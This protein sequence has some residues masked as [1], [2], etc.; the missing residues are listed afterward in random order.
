MP[1]GLRGWIRVLKLFLQTGIRFAGLSAGDHSN[2]IARKIM[3][4]LSRASSS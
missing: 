4:A 1:W 2:S 3:L